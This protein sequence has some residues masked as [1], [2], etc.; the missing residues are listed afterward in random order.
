MYL[1]DLIFSALLSIVCLSMSIQSDIQSK[2]RTLIV[3]LLPK[4]SRRYSTN[5]EDIPDGW[6][7]VQ[8]EF[9]APQIEIY[10]MKG[11]VSLTEDWT[12]IKKYK[13]SNTDYEY[14]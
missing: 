1:R 2:K 3:R 13:Y 4:P 10:L 5:L 14:V 7:I 8:P 11:Y 6:K 12:F 9:K